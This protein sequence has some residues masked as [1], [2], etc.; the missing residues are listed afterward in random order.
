[1]NLSDTIAVVITGPFFLA[2]ADRGVGADDVIVALPFIGVDRDPN[3]GEGVN[4]FFESFPVGMM[5]HAQAHLPT[6]TTYGPN[7]R[8]TVIIVSAM[9]PSFIGPTAGWIIRITVIVTFFPPRSE[10]SRQFQSVHLSRGFEAGR[11]GHWLE[12]LGVLGGLFG[13]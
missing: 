12:F 11:V 13:D 7:D 1:M 3:L 5:C 9:P 4:L 2:V 10:T 6:I 8:G